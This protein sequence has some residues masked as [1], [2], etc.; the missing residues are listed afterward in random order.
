V[1][2][3]APGRLRAESLVPL[4]N[5]DLGV[6]RKGLACPANERAV[7][8]WSAFGLFTSNPPDSAFDDAITIRTELEGR[9]VLGRFHLNRS[10]SILAPRLWVQIGA[11]CEP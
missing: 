9:R 4:A 5:A 3:S 2:P 7:S 6:Q 10:F 1:P 11:V 8:S